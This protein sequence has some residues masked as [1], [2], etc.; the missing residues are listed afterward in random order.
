MLQ[1]PIYP[2]SANA[3]Y[4]RN[5]AHVL[6]YQ[7]M[8]SQSATPNPLRG[9]SSSS[10]GGIEALKAKAKGRGKVLNASTAGKA[11]VKT[12]TSL[13]SSSKEDAAAAV[14]KRVGGNDSSSA[15]NPWVRCVMDAE[16]S[17]RDE[18][19]DDPVLA[20]AE[21]FGKGEAFEKRLTKALKAESMVLQGLTPPG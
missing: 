19:F 1:N 6:S 5:P 21:L 13:D 12:N 11:V 16:R 8:P 7:Q 3:S 15:E 14:A 4:D 2:L 20:A 18:D 10:G 9:S 17:K